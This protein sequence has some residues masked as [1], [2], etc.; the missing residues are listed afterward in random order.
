MTTN[1]RDARVIRTA[2]LVWIKGAKL[3]SGGSIYTSRNG[4]EPHNRIDYTIHSYPGEPGERT[5]WFWR[6]NGEKSHNPPGSVRLY[7]DAQLACA[8]HFLQ[9]EAEKRR[10]Q[11]EPVPVVEVA[12]VKLFLVTKQ[13]VTGLLV[14]VVAA[15][16]PVGARW[17]VYAG[18][19]D[20]LDCTELPGCVP[21][22]GFT[23][24]IK[25]EV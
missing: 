23:G 19:D 24:C 1:R 5:K 20:D 22:D 6:Y 15:I 11:P 12:P 10:V 21:P 3:L 9:L 18:R 14:W 13:S 8:K 2:G 7:R 17:F 4:F 16:D 25:T